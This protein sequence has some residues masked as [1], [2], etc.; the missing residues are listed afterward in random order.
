MDSHEKG[1]L[2]EAIAIAE[3]KRLSIPV[4]L[5]YGDNERYDLVL[6]TPNG[7]FVR[8]QVKTGWLADGKIQ[9]HARSQHTNSQGNT[10]KPYDGDIDY[11]AVYSHE[12][13]TLYL[14]REDEF[15]SSIS[16]RVDEPKIENR[17]INW[18]NE[19]E[20]DKRWPPD[21]DA[22]EVAVSQ[23]ETITKVIQNLTDQDVGV[24][25]PVSSNRSQL[26]IEGSDGELR[27]MRVKSGWIDDGRIRYNHEKIPD[28]ID[29][30]AIYVPE[31]GKLYI[32]PRGEF[33]S[34]IVLR[35][36]DPKKNNS[37]INWAE[38]FEFPREVPWDGHNS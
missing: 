12:L 26:I 17:R 4:S 14:I 38:D 6:E 5:P 30:L 9:F 27:R 31:T 37:R 10:Y 29:Y 21:T 23:R 11:F 22:R 24:A 20:F 8:V 36:D 13:E 35:V 25:K 19:F 34:S 18:A 1:D 7:D 2:T 33:E 16:L 32:V 15:G 3:L 28:R